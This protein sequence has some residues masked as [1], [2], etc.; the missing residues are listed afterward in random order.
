L[1]AF[2]AE[3][4]AAFARVDATVHYHALQIADFLRAVRDN[5]PPLVTG[6]AGRAVVELFTAIYR[7]SHE[8][9]A[10]ALPLT[11]GAA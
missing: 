6:E 4:R 8:R 3:D 2:Q 9:K 11:G 5:R 10:I 7:S 1:A